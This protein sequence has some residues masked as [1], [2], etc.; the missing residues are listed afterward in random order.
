MAS[1]ALDYGE[2]ETVVQR[3]GSWKPRVMLNP[4]AHLADESL[5]VGAVADK[6]GT[7]A[8]VGGGLAIGSE[9]FTANVDADTKRL[10]GQLAKQIKKLYV[11]RGWMSDG[12]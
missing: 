9:A 3:M 12:L 4:Y 2:P 5:G 10:A 1:L 6:V 7:A 8:V 11:Y